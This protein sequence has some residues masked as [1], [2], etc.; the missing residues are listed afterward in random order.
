MDLCKEIVGIFSVAGLNEQPDL[1]SQE[2][3]ALLYVLPPLLMV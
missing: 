3:T 1:F 2:I